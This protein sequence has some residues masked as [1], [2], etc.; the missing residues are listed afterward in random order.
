MFEGKLPLPNGLESTDKAMWIAEPFIR[1]TA[2]L[3]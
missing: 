2:G 1:E 3:R